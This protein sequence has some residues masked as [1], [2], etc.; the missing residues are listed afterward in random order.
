MNP[1]TPVHSQSLLSVPN[2]IDIS[3]VRKLARRYAYGAPGPSDLSKKQEKIKEGGRLEEEEVVVDFVVVDVVVVDVDTEVEDVIRRKWWWMLCWWMWI[4]RRKTR[5]EEGD[6]GY[7][8]S[9]QKILLIIQELNK[10]V[11]IVCLQFYQ[12]ANS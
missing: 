10:L 6:G 8:G 2:F 11:Y 7:G 4:R 12:Q 1:E 3:L 5:G 9:E